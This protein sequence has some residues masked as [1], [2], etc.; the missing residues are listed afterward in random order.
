MTL[1][2]TEPHSL[3]SPV[4]HNVLT[5]MILRMSQS[6]LQLVRRDT[7]W[8]YEVPHGASHD[9][10][11]DP[12][13]AL[14]A[15]PEI[16]ETGGVEDVVEELMARGRS[17]KRHFEAYE[18]DMAEI[19]RLLPIVRADDPKKYGPRKLEGMIE[20]MLERG[21]I[22]RLTAEAAGTSRKPA[23]DD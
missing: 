12:G 1:I 18:R 5:P 7:P 9:T 20:G 10:N 23:A 15:Q 8:Y 22:S 2:A 21:T 17:A 4:L 19:R 14:A 3:P 11:R 13:H 16:T 6:M